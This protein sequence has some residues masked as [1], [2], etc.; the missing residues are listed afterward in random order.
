MSW[1]RVWI[2]LVFSTKNRYPYFNSNEIRHKVFAHIKQN[3][4]TKNIWLDTI[5]GYHDHVHCL[6]S[7]NREDSISRTVKMIKGESS[8]W[9]NKDKIVKDKFSWQDDYW[10]VG[11]SEN[12]VEDVRKY[13]LSQERHHR[14]HTFAEEIEKFMLKYGWLAKP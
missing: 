7:L 5:S 4:K 9:I 12:Q 3:A 10:A 13:I 14:K 8:N 2:H 11:I 1:V 6:I